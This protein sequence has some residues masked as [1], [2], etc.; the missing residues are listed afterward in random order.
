MDVATGLGWPQSLPLPRVAVTR[1]QELNPF[2]VDA[3][4]CG[5]MGHGAA[6]NDLLQKFSS[7]GMLLRPALTT[8][9]QPMAPCPSPT[10]GSVPRPWLHIPSQSTQSTYAALATPA[11]ICPASPPPAESAITVDPPS[12]SAESPSARTTWGDLMDA[13]E[14]R[15]ELVEEVAQSAADELWPGPVP[16][17]T[18]SSLSPSAAPPANPDDVPAPTGATSAPDE[19]VATH[20]VSPTPAPTMPPLS[21]AKQKALLDLVRP[22]WLYGDQSVADNVRPLSLDHALV[23]SPEVLDTAIAWMLLQRRDMA[24]HLRHWL[25]VRNTP[26]RD[27]QQVLEQLDLH[28]LSLEEA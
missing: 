1:V 22:L 19:D 16:A 4:A 18:V 28:L 25:S 8:I 10:A 14:A 23:F 26:E 21:V 9:V 3:K 27:P 11:T 15:G 12:V 5:G 13:A 24:A 2:G 17:A 7:P 20:D 6:L